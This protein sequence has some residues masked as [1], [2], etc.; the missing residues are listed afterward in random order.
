MAGR[1]DAKIA[2][3]VAE[4]GQVCG[5]AET[6]SGMEAFLYQNGSISSLGTLGGLNSHAYGINSLS[7]IVARTVPELYKNAC[8]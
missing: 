7:Q 6:P 8:S 5:V 4:L 2:S 3:F 1:T